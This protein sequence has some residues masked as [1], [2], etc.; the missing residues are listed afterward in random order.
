MVEKGFLKCVPVSVYPEFWGMAKIKQ[1][2]HHPIWSTVLMMLPIRKKKSMGFWKV[3]L[4]YEAVGFLLVSIVWLLQELAV[5]QRNVHILAGV[6]VAAWYGMRS[7]CDKDLCFYHFKLKLLQC[8]ILAVVFEDYMEIT[9]GWEC[10]YLLTGR[11]D[12]LCTG[13]QWIFKSSSY[14][15]C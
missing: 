7:P 1:K 2:S 3:K 4:C 8:A 6:L 12:S 13:C 5:D 9:V 10:S 14:N 11:W 15:W